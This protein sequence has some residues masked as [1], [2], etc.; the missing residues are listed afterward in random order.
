MWSWCPWVQE[1]DDYA[2]PS[3]LEPTGTSDVV[4]MRGLLCAI[5]CMGSRQQGLGCRESDSRDNLARHCAV[6]RCAHFALWRRMSHCYVT[7]YLK[8]SSLESR[9]QQTV[10][11]YITFLQ[12]APLP[13]N[14]DVSATEATL[15]QLCM[16]QEKGQSV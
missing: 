8:T 1:E 6:L 3:A 2:P 14:Q 16:Q 12:L 7:L 9:Q 11:V 5:F 4:A 13:D 15:W 10:R